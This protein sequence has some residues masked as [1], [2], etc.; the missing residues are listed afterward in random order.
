MMNQ[1]KMD[2]AFERICL[3]LLFL[4]AISFMNWAGYIICLVFFVFLF[5]VAR[6]P[7]LLDRNFFVLLYNS[8][9]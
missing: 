4:F 8:L 2:K 1:Y 5:V 9:S 3:L 6:Y 7:L